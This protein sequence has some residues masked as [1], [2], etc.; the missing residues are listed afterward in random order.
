MGPSPTARSPI[1]IYG[2]KGVPQH[3]IGIDEKVGILHPEP[4]PHRETEQ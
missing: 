1:Q 4:G 3:C 2:Q